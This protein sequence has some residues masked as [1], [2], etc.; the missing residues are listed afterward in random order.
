MVIVIDVLN[1]LLTHILVEVL[2]SCSFSSSLAGYGVSFGYRILEMLGF[3]HLCPPASDTEV[4][5]GL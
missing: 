4:F 1:F 5:N 3:K 2:I